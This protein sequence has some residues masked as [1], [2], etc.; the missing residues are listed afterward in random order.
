MVDVGAKR[1]T[2]RIAR[3]TGSI[4][5]LPETFALV[6]GG[7]AKFVPVYAKVV[8]ATPQEFLDKAQ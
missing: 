7:H 8:S 4:R 3:A 2:H 6:A 1:E 5:M